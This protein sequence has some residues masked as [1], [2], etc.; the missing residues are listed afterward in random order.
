MIFIRFKLLLF[1]S[2]YNGFDK[3]V[4]VFKVI[5]FL[6]LLKYEIFYFLVLLIFFYVFEVFFFKFL[7]R[8]IIV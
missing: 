6:F 8:L 3:N 1:N 5:E 4:L 7:V 2:Y